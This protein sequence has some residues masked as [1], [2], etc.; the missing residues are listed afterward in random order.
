MTHTVREALAALHD[1]VGGDMRGDG[2][3]IRTPLATIE[4]LGL[5]C[6]IGDRHNRI[7]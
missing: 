6:T 3:V 1:A 2:E 7:E 4:Q 5:E